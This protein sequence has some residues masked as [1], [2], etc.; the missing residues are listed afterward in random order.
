MPSD[1]ILTDDYIT[2]LL[3]ND[4]KDRT[5]KYSAQGLEAFLPNRSTSSARK[6]NTRFLKNVIRETDSHN[7]AL[8]AKETSE[9]R[10]RLRELQ[11]GERGLFEKSDGSGHRT[12]IR[13][14]DDK[15]IKEGNERRR[16]P[17]QELFQYRHRHKDE[18]R[19]QSRHRYHYEEEAPRKNSSTRKSPRDR[20]TT[21][22]RDLTKGED[23]SQKSRGSRRHHRSDRRQHVY[24]QRSR[25]RSPERERSYRRSRY[26]RHHRRHDSLSSTQSQNQPS[27]QGVGSQRLVVNRHT[28]PSHSNRLIRSSSKGEGVNDLQEFKAP[29]SPTSCTSSDPLES[30]IGPAPPSRSPSP[31]IRRRGRG[32][33]RSI[34][35]TID[36]HFATTYDPALDVHPNSASEDDWDQALEALKDRQKWKQQGADRLRQA[37]F[38]EKDI[39]KWETGGEKREVDVRWA[40]RGEGREWDRGKRVEDDDYGRLI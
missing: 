15:A 8:R 3:V 5:L 37:G 16:R 2:N 30:L 28:P 9:S 35:T 25:S 40:S 26:G 29:L 23:T 18:H 32:A 11:Q 19:T 12:K 36:T 14:I 33:A 20:S 34:H 17:D 22:E 27:R 10:L 24:L 38:S 31:R 1:D 7:A 13:R 21:R 4:A 39:E 6:P